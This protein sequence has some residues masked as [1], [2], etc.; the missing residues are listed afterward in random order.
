MYFGNILLYLND[1]VEQM[2]FHIRYRTRNNMCEVN[3]V[4]DSYRHV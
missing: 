4:M 1:I 2:K 3:G